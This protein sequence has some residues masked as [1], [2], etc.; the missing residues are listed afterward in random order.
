[1]TMVQPKP[2][3]EPDSATRL[4]RRP[5][6]S[7]LARAPA[8]LLTAL[9]VVGLDPA[10]HAGTC[11]LILAAA[12]FARGSP[13]LERLAARTSKARTRGRR[14]A[15]RPGD[16]RPGQDRGLRGDGAFGRARQRSG[17]PPIAIALRACAGRGRRAY[18]GTRPSG[19]GNAAEPPRPG[20]RDAQRRDASTMGLRTANDWPSASRRSRFAP[21]YQDETIETLSKAIAEQWAMIDRLKREI[22]QHGRTARR[23]AAGAGPV[24]RPSAAL[25]SVAAIRP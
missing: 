24:D 7:R 15:A 9:G 19:A 4:E 18:V 1:M 5:G 13:R 21:A 2:Q 11:F 3:D 10:G 17:A 14:V 22:A 25:L 12:C 16:P 20:R 8:A 23:A 6:A